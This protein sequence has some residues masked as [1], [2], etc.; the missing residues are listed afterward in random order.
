MTR[1]SGGVATCSQPFSTL[2]ASSQTAVVAPAPVAVP[3]MPA[4]EK[5]PLVEPTMTDT[6]SAFFNLDGVEAVI[7]G[8]VDTC[9]INWIRC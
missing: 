6:A 1:V 2:N 4:V 9:V 3:V 8:N 7:E 5:P